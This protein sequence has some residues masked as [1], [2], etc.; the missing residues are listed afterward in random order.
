M[1]INENLVGGASTTTIPTT[2]QAYDEP[3]TIAPKPTC[4]P[5]EGEAAQNK[6]RAGCLVCSL[7]RDPK[8]SF[9]VF[10]RSPI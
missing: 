3:P 1:I 6:I 5:T 4:D 2:T 8:K 9:K 10:C 7:W